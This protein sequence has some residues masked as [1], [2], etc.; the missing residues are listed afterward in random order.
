LQRLF[1]T[2]PAGRPGLGLLVL[3]IAVFVILIIQGETYLASTPDPTARGEHL[4][5]IVT[6][7]GVLKIAAGALLLAGF[8]T[9]FVG[10]SVAVGELGIAFSGMPSWSAGASFSGTWF[11]P[12]FVATIAGALVLLGP[13][14]FSIDARLFGRREVIIPPSQPPRP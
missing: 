3:R 14:A 9:P 10:L 13:G 1:S 6:T 4:S 5:A 7:L 2:F 8:V 11:T 12:V